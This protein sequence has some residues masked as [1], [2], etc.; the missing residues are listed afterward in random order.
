MDFYQCFTGK[1]VFYPKKTSKKELLSA[2]QE[3]IRENFRRHWL[4]KSK[5]RLQKFD[6][7]KFFCSKRLLD[8]EK[9]VKRCLFVAFE[10]K[11][12]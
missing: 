3:N 5:T 2:F 12:R 8:S 6:F 1:R 9:H 7:N 10:K 4:S 11:N